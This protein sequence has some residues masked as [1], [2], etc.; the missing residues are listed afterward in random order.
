MKRSNHQRKG[1]VIILF[2]AVTAVGLLLSM[3]ALTYQGGLIRQTKNLAT[4]QAVFYLAES[5]IERAINRFRADPNYTGETFTLGDGQVTTSVTAGATA[6]EKYLKAVGQIGSLS[7]KLQVKFTTQSTGVPV[8]FHYALQSGN[9]GFQIGNNSIINGN[10]YSNASISGGNNSRITGDAYAVGS[11]TNVIVSGQTKTGQA[12]QPFPP[13][14]DAFWKSKAQA[15]G[16]ISGNYTPAPNST[17]GPLYITGNLII[18]N[19]VTVTVSGPVYVDGLITFGNAPVLRVD[20]SLGTSGTMFISKQTITFGNSITVSNNQ[21]GG[22]L[23]MISTNAATAISI[24]NNAGAIQAPLYAPY[25]T[26]N[27]GNNVQAVAFTG[28]RI[29][30]GTGASVIYNQGLAN[31]SFSSGP[32]GGWQLETGT[33]QEYD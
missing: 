17:I 31:A 27:I 26:I 8:A 5:G 23:L 28:N 15:G 21:Q 12:S 3:A 25:G 14:D 1:Q 32:S 22:Y 6:N 4:R 29:I 2:L 7:R 13:F 30:L 19:N 10:V 20:N 16:T 18:N 33:F 11:V 24:G 9:G